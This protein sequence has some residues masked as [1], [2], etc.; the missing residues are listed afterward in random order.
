MDRHRLTHRVVG[1]VSR[2]R[3]PADQRQGLDD[4]LVCGIAA[5]ERQ[6][7]Q[8]PDQAAPVV[9][10]VGRLQRGRHGAP[11]DRAL[12]LELVHQ[13]PQRLLTA[14]H[15]G[16]H[17]LA[18]RVI[19]GGPRR[20]GDLEQDVFLAAHPLEGVDQLGGDLLLCPGGDP[21]HGGDQQVHQRVG[22]LPFPLVQQRCQQRQPQRHRVRTQVRG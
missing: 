2:F 9:V 16:E 15:R 6:H 10:G 7:A 3:V 13:L 1:D 20:L 18:D 5:A 8:Q 14:G 11:V 12:G 17:H 4:R 19:R 21:V 22:D